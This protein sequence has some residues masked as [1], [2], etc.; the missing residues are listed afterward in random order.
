MRQQFTH[1][2]LMPGMAASPRIFDRLQLPEDSFR[3]HRLQWK[4]PKYQETIEAYARR[5]CAEI[6]HKDPVLLGVSFGGVLVQEMAK[7]LKVKR[8]I[9]V[10]SVKHHDEMPSRMHW[11]RRSQLYRVFPT[12]LVSRINNWERLAIG[13]FAKKRARLYQEYLSVNDKYYLDWSIRNMIYWKQKESIQEVIHIHGD[14]DVIFP[15][16]R[17]NNCIKIKGGTHIMII[18]KAAWFNKNLPKLIHQNSVS[19]N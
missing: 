8:V 10:S 7:H 3:L 15:I 19:L 11:V 13:S 5:M 1:I 2:Y 12:A 9:V 17:I 4:I 6:C 16:H 18:D 14:K